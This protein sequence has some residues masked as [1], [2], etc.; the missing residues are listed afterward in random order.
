MRKLLETVRT[1]ALVKYIELNVNGSKR[2]DENTTYDYAILHD[3]S[4]HRFF[5]GNRTSTS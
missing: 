5:N 1:I 2:Y 3:L 4:D